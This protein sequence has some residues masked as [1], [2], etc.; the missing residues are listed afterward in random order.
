MN[1][2]SKPR[3]CLLIRKLSALIFKGI[4]ERQVLVPL[5]LLF[6]NETAKDTEKGRK[7]QSVG[8]SLFPGLPLSQGGFREPSTRTDYG[9]RP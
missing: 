5:V 9:C 4:V 6:C 2:V 3:L 1:P 8:C 7:E